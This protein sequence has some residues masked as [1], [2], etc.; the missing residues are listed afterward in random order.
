VT[1]P[2]VGQESR[3]DH[4]S[5]LQPTPD[6]SSNGKSKAIDH[7]DSEEDDASDDTSEEEGEVDVSV[8]VGPSPKRGRPRKSIIQEAVKRM[9]KH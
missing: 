7:S 6:K 5:P 9:K 3:G 8:A 4:K 1:K 2:T